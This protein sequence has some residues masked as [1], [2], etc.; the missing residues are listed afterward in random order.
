MSIHFH[1]LV[2]EDVIRETEDAIIVGFRVPAA[3]TSMFRFLPGQNITVRSVVDGIEL[4]RSYSICSEPGDS[5]LRIA[6]REVPGGKFSA[7]AVRT[8]VKGHIA[9]VLPPTGRFVVHPDAAH[10]KKYLAIAAGSGITPVFAIICSVL[11]VE[12]GSN[13]TLL[14]GNRTQASIIFREQLAALKNRYMDR[15]A[16]HHFLSRE[17]TDPGI[18]TGRLDAARLGELDHKLV[19]FAIMDEIFICGP[20]SMTFEVKN[21]LLEKGIPSK[22]IHVELF[23]VPDASGRFVES[24]GNTGY[25]LQQQVDDETSAGKATTPSINEQ[26]QKSTGPIEMNKLPQSQRSCR[27]TVKADGH[28]YVFDLPMDGE[29]ILNAALDYGADLPFSCKGGVCGTCRARLI[30]GRVE[31]ELN[32]ALEP[33]EVKAGYILTCQSHPL[34]ETVTV[35]F[36]Q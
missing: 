32:Y 27:V 1:K 9:D 13:F 7:W 28:N 30:E 22:K 6:I 20:S 17:V 25:L 23:S 29:K 21:W 31:M 35:D 11:S 2:I 12:Q 14:Y 19:D 15:F 5:L 18:Y 33:G 3:L 26:A 34:T 24:E 8:F 16:L 36:D 10:Q 4:R